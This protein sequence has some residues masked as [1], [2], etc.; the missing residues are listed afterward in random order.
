[1]LIKIAVSIHV[2]FVFRI[3]IFLI[4]FCQDVYCCNKSY[5]SNMNSSNYLFFPMSL[6]ITVIKIY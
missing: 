4:T 6:H 2:F 1:M 3:T 5:I